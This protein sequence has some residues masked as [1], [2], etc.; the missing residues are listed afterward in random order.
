M[1]QLFLKKEASF[2]RQ[3]SNDVIFYNFS[4]FID[5]RIITNLNVN[6]IGFLLIFNYVY[7]KL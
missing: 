5:E 2:I 3:N 7:L 6:V 1:F 4:N